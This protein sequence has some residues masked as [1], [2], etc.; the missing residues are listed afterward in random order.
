MKRVLVISLVLA[1]AA[2]GA[3][4]AG[5]AAGSTAVENPGDI[6]LYVTAGYRWS[7]EVEVAAEIIFGDFSLGALACDLGFMASG[8]FSFHLGVQYALGAQATLHLSAIANTDFLIAVGAQY[9][10]GV[11]TGSPIELALGVELSYWFAPRVALVARSSIW[12][13][14]SWGVGLEF[15]I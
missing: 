6:N 2:C 10:S 11:V 15:K 9:V 3:F 14:I 8:L 1:G 13:G 4:G 5:N 12:N 7:P